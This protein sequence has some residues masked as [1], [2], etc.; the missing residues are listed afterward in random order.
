MYRS[1]KE[2]KR[3]ARE[4]LTGHYNVPMGAFIVSSMITLM[5]ELPFSM[6]ES[7]NPAAMQTIISYVARVLISLISVVLNAGILK[8][9]LQMARKKEYA[10]NLLFFYLKNRPDRYLVSGFIMMLLTLIASLPFLGTLY[11]YNSDATTKH[12]LLA[13]GVGIL[14]LLICIY[15]QLRLQLLYYIIIEQE[16]LS[17]KEAFQKAYA[18]TK[19]QTGRLLLIFLSFLG[20]DLLGALSL[21]IG[22]LWIAPYQSQVITL[23]YLDLIDDIPKPAFVPPTTPQPIYFNQYI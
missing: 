14:C 4:N 23:F 19:G 8:I 18:I 15:I 9:H 1:I 21:G 12:L 10:P 5:I 7:E 17:V 20:Y 3:L 11:L 2:I 13:I 22:M 6:F 16:N